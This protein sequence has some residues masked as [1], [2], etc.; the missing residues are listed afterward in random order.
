MAAES[1]R[2]RVE[3]AYALPDEQALVSLEVEPGT[4]VQE[5][6]ERSRI[7]DRFP[8]EDLADRA[9]G[10]WGH[11]VGRQKQV[12]D[13]DRVEIYRELAIDPREARRRLAC[14]GKTMGSL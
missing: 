6:I 4:T 7:A 14:R 8:G 11:R 3:V 1:V 12:G 9:V 13:G 5:A 2:L 10:I